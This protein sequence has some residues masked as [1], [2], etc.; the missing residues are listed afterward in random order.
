MKR[1]VNKMH[2]SRLKSKLPFNPKSAIKNSFPSPSLVT[3]EYHVT[4]LIKAQK[5]IPHPS[6]PCNYNPPFV[7]EE[8]DFAE[9][10]GYNPRRICLNKV[11]DRWG[12]TCQQ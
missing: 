8:L 2:E 3:F 7:V 5:N 12:L 9:P 6:N 4:L 11:K 10:N 1:Y